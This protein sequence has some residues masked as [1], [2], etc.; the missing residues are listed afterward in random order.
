[1]LSDSGEI[2]SKIGKST[3]R[4]RWLAR[5]AQWREEKVEVVRSPKRPARRKQRC[6][7]ESAERRECGLFRGRLSGE[8]Q[9]DDEST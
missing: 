3:P 7:G 9:S 8:K 2:W 5:K 1:L 4:Q 6:G